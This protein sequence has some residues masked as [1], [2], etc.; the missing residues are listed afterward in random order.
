MS[1]VPAVTGDFKWPGDQSTT[2]ATG[3]FWETSNGSRKL[4]F[5]CTQWAHWA[6]QWEKVLM[7]VFD[8]IDSNNWSQVTISKKVWFEPGSDRFGHILNI[9]NT[10][11]DLRFSSAISLN[12][13]PNLGP[14]LHCPRA[15]LRPSGP[16]ADPGPALKGQGKGQQISLGSAL[17]WPWPY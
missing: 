10:D 8:M 16:G 9:A 11:P 3:R 5:F 6:I 14:V 7:I 1:A 15:G 2:Q 13:D 17:G 12:F 4:D